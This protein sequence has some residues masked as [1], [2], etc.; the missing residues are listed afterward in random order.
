MAIV[1]QEYT[2]A[3]DDELSVKAGE[4]VTI[5]DDAHP[6]WDL[7]SAG[8]SIGFLPS[9]V[10]AAMSPSNGQVPVISPHVAPVEPAGMSCKLCFGDA[11]A[12]DPSG[13]Q[14]K[15]KEPV[16]I[17]DIHLNATSCPGCGL[18]SRVIEHSQKHVGDETRFTKVVITQ[19]N[20]KS[21]R[22]TQIRLLSSTNDCYFAVLG[23]SNLNH[24]ERNS[25]TRSQCMWI[26]G[27]TSL[28]LDR[29]RI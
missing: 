25:V 3:D 26:L 15:G 29:A 27:V 21:S 5:Y 7:V 17:Q 10:F 9:S 12:Q 2:A 16:D 11:L 20:Y 4:L 6:L 28:S 14:S 13:E 23:F 19:G 22:T 18:L 24:E 1:Q 8:G